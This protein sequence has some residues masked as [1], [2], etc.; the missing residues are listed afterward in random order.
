MRTGADYGRAWHR[1]RSRGR[2]GCTPPR[3]A[4]RADADGHGEPR[5]T[6]GRCVR[7]RNVRSHQ[8]RIHLTC[9]RPI[10][11]AGSNSP[12]GGTLFSRRDREPLVCAQQA[13]LLRVLQERWESSSALGSSR[14]AAVWTCAF[15]RRRTRTC[16]R[17]S[18]LDGS[19]RTGFSASTRW[20]FISRALREQRDDIPLLAGH[21]L[22]AVRGGGIDA[23][24]HRFL[25]G[26]HARAACLYMA[27]QCSRAGAPRS[28]ARHCSRRARR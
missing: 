9:R 5:R 24:S 4:R 7:E 6:L 21:F 28:S 8:G 15:S 3:R 16:A 1:E 14:S 17:K 2:L 11:S 19:A 20:R 13:K 12:D 25:A 27:G 22:Q 10:V 26:R 18:R 23:R